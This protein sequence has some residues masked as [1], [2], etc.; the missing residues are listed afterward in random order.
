MLADPSS[1]FDQESKTVME[2]KTTR[3]SAGPRRIG[4]AG[5]GLGLL[6]LLFWASGETRTNLADL[7]RPVDDDPVAA[8]RVSRELDRLRP[9]GVYV[10]IDTFNNRLS[11]RRGDATL[12]EAVCS[13]GTGF[14]LDD[15]PTG[16]QWI[17]ETPRGVHRV[18]AKVRRP[19]WRKPDWAFLEEGKPIPTRASE[20]FDPAA[21]G[22]YALD[23]GDGYL[24]HGTL[25]RRLLGQSATHGCIRLDDEDLEAVYHTV[26]TGS[27][28][29]IH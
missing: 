17:F 23:L 1:P 29:F 25:Y 12:R 11:L 2:P 5:L 3:G 20:R 22:A 26:P 15:P 9:R 27:A 19:V 4:A 18:R 8:E 7:P 24:I 28:V 13:T 21:L 10:V 14:L 16:R 6:L